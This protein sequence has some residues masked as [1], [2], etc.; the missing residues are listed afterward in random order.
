MFSKDKNSA[1]KDPSIRLKEQGNEF[2][3]QKKYENA[4][5]CFN[6]AIEQ[7]KTNPTIYFNRAKTHKVL[8]NFHA[9]LR[10][11]NEAAELND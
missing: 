5:L 6:Q 4:L 11:A 1:S 8:Q 3:K 9:M 7:N 2:F 10:D